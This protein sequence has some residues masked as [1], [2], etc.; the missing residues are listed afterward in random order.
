M[1]GSAG[2]EVLLS[3]ALAGWAVPDSVKCHLLQ[4]FVQLHLTS[5]SSCFYLCLESSSCTT[6]SYSTSLLYSPLSVSTIAEANGLVRL[7]RAQIASSSILPGS[8]IS[9]QST[10]NRP[11]H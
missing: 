10:P 9:I 7:Q 2:Q 1:R 3:S 5:T 4:P 8:N 6:S 11:G